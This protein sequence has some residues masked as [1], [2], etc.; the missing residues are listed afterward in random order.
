M[1]YRSQAFDNLLDQAANESDATQRAATLERAE[2]LALRDAPVIP[3]FYGVARHLVKPT[4]AGWYNNV[5]NVTYSK[6]LT[7]SVA[8]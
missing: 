7:V 6:D 2:S 1:H 8:H 4:I 5:M 3:L